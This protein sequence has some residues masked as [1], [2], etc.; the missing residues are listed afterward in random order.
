MKHKLLA[1]VIAIFGL[2]VPTACGGENCKLVDG[3]EV[4]CDSNQAMD[5]DGR[6]I[7]RK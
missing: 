6:C 4:C 3:V 7:P 2:I 1:L 5:G